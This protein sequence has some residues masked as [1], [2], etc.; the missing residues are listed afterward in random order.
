M[1]MFP[2][3]SAACHQLDPS[4]PAEWEVFAFEKVKPKGAKDW[5]QIHVQGAIK[6]DKS[7]WEEHVREFFLPIE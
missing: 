2:T 5:A 4:L 6:G 1:I 7:Q 3:L